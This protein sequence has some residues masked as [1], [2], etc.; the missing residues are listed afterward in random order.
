MN[1]KTQFL[2]TVF[3]VITGSASAQSEPD[4]V[5]KL[6]TEMFRAHGSKTLCLPPTGAPVESIRSSL[7]ARLRAEGPHTNATGQKA[8][9]ALWAL[10]PC[11]F[12]PAR[13][14]LR[15]A[16]TEDTEGA[17]VYASES[18]FLR[19]GPSTT[20]QP[21]LGPLAITCEAVGYFSDGEL[22]TAIITGQSKCP[23]ESASA[24]D[25]VRQFPRVSSWRFL[26]DG[27]IAVTR[28]DVLNHIEEWDVYS[29]I[30]PFEFSGVRFY[31]GDLVS[32][33]R[34]GPGNEVGAATQFRH[35]KRL[36]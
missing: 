6:I 16:T 8:A 34:R 11:P 32:Y 29:V 21:F 7:L 31:A 14:E 33:A 10:Y 30:E 5:T 35:L 13:K 26:R 9:E 36:H 4:P 2:L 25:A 28:T 1:F 3:L 20:Q 15:V 23:F 27:R 12:A 24:F 22:R 18:Q 17:W 19:R